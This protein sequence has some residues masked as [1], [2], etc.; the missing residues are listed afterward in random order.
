VV[1]RHRF[2]SRLAA[3]FRD[4]PLCMIKD[5]LTLVEG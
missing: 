2:R 4:E 5:L 3:G 1:Q